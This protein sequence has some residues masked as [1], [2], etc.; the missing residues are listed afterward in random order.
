M[1]KKIFINKNKKFNDDNKENMHD[2]T[3]AIYKLKVFRQYIDS[4]YA[5]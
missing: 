4:F 5:K 1:P 2:L 3:Q